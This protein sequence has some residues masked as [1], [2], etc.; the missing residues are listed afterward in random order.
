MSVSVKFVERKYADTPS[1]EVVFRRIAEGL[2]R[3]GVKTAFEKLP[4]G[5]GIFGIFRNLF[6][7]RGGVADIF[8]ITG[9][10]HYIGLVLPP[11]RTVLTIHDLGILKVRSGLRRWVIKKLLFDWPVRRLKYITAISEAT[12]QDLVRATGCEPGKIRV[13]QNP[14]PERL[15][16]KR[17]LPA[18]PPVILHIGAAPHKNLESLAEAINGFDC[19]LRVIGQLDKQQRGLLD[20][21]KIRYDSVGPI[22]DREMADEYKNADLLVFCSTFEGFGMPIIEAQAAGLPVIT[23]DLEPMNDV[24]GGGALLVDPNKPSEI[25]RAIGE[26]LG[27]ERTRAELI[28]RGYENVS[29]FSSEKIVGAYLQLY[30]EVLG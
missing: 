28:D 5:N 9:H 10:S 16:E 17:R 13:I 30:E 15:N 6:S 26:M 20:S 7:Y 27:N 12:K 22:G 29:R 1:I 19:R 2:E 4:Y 11:D 18:A 23:S 24:A 3:K 25:R 14:A 8:H 21:L